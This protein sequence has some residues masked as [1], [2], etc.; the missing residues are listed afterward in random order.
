MDIDIKL[1]SCYRPSKDVVAREVMG[2]ILIVP[3]KSGIGDMEDEIFTLNETA[4]AIWDELAG[5]KSVREVIEALSGTFEVG[6]E[7]I[8]KDV[9]GLMK[10]L[11]RRGII[12]E[13]I[14]D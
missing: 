4:K 11:A 9:T 8:K 6:A 14:N 12:E 13:A 10:E 1:D 2:K 3:L 7:E 5:N